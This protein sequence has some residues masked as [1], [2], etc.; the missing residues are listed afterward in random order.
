[1]DDPNPNEVRAHGSGRGYRKETRGRDTL[2]GSTAPGSGKISG[3]GWQRVTDVELA[4][5]L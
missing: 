3:F 5:Q 2:L 4:E 1:M